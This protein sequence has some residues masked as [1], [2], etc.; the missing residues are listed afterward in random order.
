MA[1][2]ILVLAGLFE[3]AWAVGLKY[4]DGFTRLLP[5]VATLAA[6]AVSV[7][8]LALAVKTLPLS[9]AYAIWTGIGAVGA[10]ILGIVLFHE[11]A[12]PARLACLALII[13]GI[14]GLKVV[15]PE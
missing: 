13:V 15:S 5:S 1:W 6:M 14:I 12:S 9:T 2:I 7:G 11:S 8:L 3:V 10:V 4:T